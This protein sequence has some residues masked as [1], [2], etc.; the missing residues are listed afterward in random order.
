MIFEKKLTA[1]SSNQWLITFVFLFIMMFISVSINAQSLIQKEI[2]NAKYEKDYEIK[3]FEVKEVNNKLYFK[4]IV[5]ENQSNTLY[6]LESSI[7]GVDFYAVQLKEGSKSPKDIP[8]LHCYSVNLDDLNDNEYRI[9]RDSPDGVEYSTILDVS[10]TN[11][12]FLSAQ[13]N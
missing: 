1:T 5:L 12:H 4:Y 7:N 2:F 10:N 9:R 6:T 3:K 13:K 11:Q 8:L